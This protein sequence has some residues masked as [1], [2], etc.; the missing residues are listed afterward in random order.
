MTYGMALQGSALPYSSFPFY[1][2]IALKVQEWSDR[3]HT[4]PISPQSL[5]GQRPKLSTS[6]LPLINC[7]NTFCSPTWNAFSPREPD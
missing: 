7:T 5:Q 4:T 6:P 2:S 3:A 1:P